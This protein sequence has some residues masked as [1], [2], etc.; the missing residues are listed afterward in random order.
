[1]T[2]SKQTHLQQSL[3][4]IASIP[5]AISIFICSILTNPSAKSLGLKTRSAKNAQGDMRCWRSDKADALQ[6]NLISLAASHPA[7]LGWLAGHPMGGWGGRAPPH[8]ADG[9]KGWFS[10]AVL[11]AAYG[12]LFERNNV[13]FCFSM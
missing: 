7:V 13:V 1:V 5:L 4:P 9:E 2:H 10:V 12:V 6:I 8:V 3:I 11:E